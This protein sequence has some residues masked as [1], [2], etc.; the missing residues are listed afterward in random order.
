MADTMRDLWDRR[1]I[2]EGI[3]IRDRRTGHPIHVSNVERIIPAPQW[4]PGAFLR[5]RGVLEVPGDA[6][7]PEATIRRLR[8]AS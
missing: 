4:A 6:A 2:V 7:P 8:D 3:V 5:A 1:A